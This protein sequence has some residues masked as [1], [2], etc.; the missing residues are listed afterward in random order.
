MNQSDDEIVEAYR[1]LARAYALIARNAPDED[2]QMGGV[3]AS[4]VT[5]ASRLAHLAALRVTY[6]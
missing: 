5:A 1:M 3:L 4:A 2:E 6:G